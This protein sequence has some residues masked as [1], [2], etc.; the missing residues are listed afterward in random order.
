MAG[1]I[2]IASTC[3]APMRNAAATSLPLPAPNGDTLGL[4]LEV[5]RKLVIGPDVAVFL[6][7]LVPAIALGEIEDLLVIG[8]ARQDVHQAIGAL[9]I[10]TSN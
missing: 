7:R 5:E 1:S 6:V 4:L 3:E 10:R 8:A 9:A 2:S